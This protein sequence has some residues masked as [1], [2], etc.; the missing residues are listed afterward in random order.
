LEYASIPVTR[1]V[2]K[3]PALNF[4]GRIII[5]YRYGDLVCPE[6]RQGSAKRGDPHRISS[7][8]KAIKSMG[9][10]FIVQSP[11]LSRWCVWN[12]HPWWLPTCMPG[13]YCRLLSC[14][15][16]LFLDNSFR[17]T[18]LITG[19]ALFFLCFAYYTILPSCSSPWPNRGVERN[20]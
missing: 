6:G 9:D 3:V 1:T 16:T 2:I 18:E 10:Y 20:I 13:I 7:I 19:V 5:P 17:K 8:N 14:P 11:P 15:G 12:N 4:S